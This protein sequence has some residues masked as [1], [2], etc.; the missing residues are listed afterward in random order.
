MSIISPDQADFLRYQRARAA[1]AGKAA[2]GMGGGGYVAPGMAVPSMQIPGLNA[3]E[4]GP[5]MYTAT[6]TTQN[7][8]SRVS[9]GKGD[10]GNIPPRSGGGRGPANPGALF[11]RNQM[12]GGLLSTGLAAA[13]LI[14]QVAQDV[15][16][17]RTLDA[18]VTGG[19]GGAI[20]T[21][22][23]LGG[24]AVGGTKGNL[25]RGAGAILAPLLGNAAGNFAEGQR[26]EDTGVAPAGASEVEQ[27]KADRS[28]TKQDAADFL[29]MNVNAMNAYTQQ[30]IDLM[31]AASDQIYL[32]N[33]RNAPMIKKYLDEQ[34]VRQQ[35]LNAS[36]TSNYAML[37][38]V[39]TAGKL[40][41]GAQEQT[42]A[43][44]RTMLSNNPYSNSVM[45]APNISF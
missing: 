18:A 29:E 1:E 38:T 21:A 19:V 7:P 4:A 12:M 23:E 17:G 34:M 10:N 39:A 43:T 44:M 32:D 5:A 16:Q 42:G 26:A 27:R 41:T 20:L 6:S 45:Q 15:G 11:P 30:N 35:A 28:R 25:I 3:L 13:P 9:S 22:T 2:F 31:K 14:G 40:A 37:G 24:R 33:Q 8:T 36:T